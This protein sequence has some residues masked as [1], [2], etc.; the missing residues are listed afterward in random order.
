MNIQS[1][2]VFL[3]IVEQRSI[4]AAARKLFFTQPTV[5]EHLNQ[6]EKKLGVQLVLRVRGARNITITPAGESFIPLA[7]RWLELDQQTQQF[8]DSQQ[9]K[10]IRLAA[11]SGAHEYIVSH[12]AHK[13]MRID[14]ELEVRLRTVEIRELDDAVLYQTFDVAFSFGDCSFPNAEVIPLFQEDRYILCPV[15]TV[16][17]DRMIAPEDLDL[18]FEVVYSSGQNK[19][20]RHWRK[21]HFA[22]RTK[23]Y[24]TVSSLSSVHNYLEDSR[25]WSLVPASIAMLRVS[26]YPDKLTIRRLDPVPLP[27]NCSLII[28]EDYPYKDVIENLKKCCREYV[29]EHHYLRGIT[30]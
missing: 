23:P 17:P 21:N 6:L 4:S 11:S 28:N 30:F 19:D 7:R 2:R 24:F 20:Y 25:C 29:Q 9:K 18:N 14:P 22:E 12:I 16:L 3:A 27:R 10:V 15:D 5:S 13:L 26:Q 8:A 1:I